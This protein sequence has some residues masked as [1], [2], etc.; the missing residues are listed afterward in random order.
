VRLRPDLKEENKRSP[1]GEL[2]SKRMGDTPDIR[3]L[4]RSVELA[5]GAKRP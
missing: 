5:R 4:R 2:L 3:V 1:V